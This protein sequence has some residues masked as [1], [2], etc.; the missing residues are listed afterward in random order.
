MNIVIIGSGNA[1]TVLGRKFKTAGHAIVQIISRNASQASEL[2]YEW[3]TE[4]A[5]YLSLIN[6]DADVY[7]IA[8]TDSAI[9]S[10]VADLRLPGKVIAHTAASVPMEVLKHVS[11]HYGVF[12]PLQSLIKE[13]NELPEIPIF[14]DGNDEFARRT[15]EKLAHS[16]SFDHVLPAGD[17]QRIKMH[18]AAVIVNNFVNHL[19]TLIEDYCRK[20]GL[21]FKQL[22]PLIEET[23]SRLEKASPKDVQTGPAIRGDQVTIDK[24]LEILEGH[25]RLK[26]LYGAITASIRHSG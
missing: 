11:T 4:S 1:A 24:H 12:Y 5:N 6:R 26:E 3:D 18:I 21:D 17:E 25:P 8:V 9:P 16:I 7:L 10:V 13:M 20:E 23:A 19:Y 15:L 22:V 2:A 14:I